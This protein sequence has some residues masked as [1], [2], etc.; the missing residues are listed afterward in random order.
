[1]FVPRAN[2]DHPVLPRSLVCIDK[3]KASQGYKIFLN[4]KPKPFL[5]ARHVRLIAAYC[6]SDVV[7]ALSHLEQEGYDNPISLA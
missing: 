4:T 7:L 5:F 1:M 3:C 6:L 2:S